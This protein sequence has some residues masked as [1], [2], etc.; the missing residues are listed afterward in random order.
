MLSLRNSKLANVF[1]DTFADMSEGIKN[2]IEYLFSR[3]FVMDFSEVMK[4]LFVFLSG[5][6]GLST[7]VF[8]IIAIAGFFIQKIFSV[9]LGIDYG[10]WIYIGELFAGFLLSVIMYV[11]FKILSRI[12]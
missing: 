4:L 5:T 2:S 7:L 11:F 12:L 10:V 8:G 1:I 9:N 6:L 3:E